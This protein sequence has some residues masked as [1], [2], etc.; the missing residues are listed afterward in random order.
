MAITIGSNSY[1]YLRDAINAAVNNDVILVGAGTYNIL[2]YTSSAPQNANVGYCGSYAPSLSRFFTGKSGINGLTIEGAVDGTT[3]APLATITNITRIYA[4]AKDRGYGLP[5]KWTINNLALQ[6]NVT[7]GSE[8]ILQ[9]GNYG[10]LTNNL[11]DL[12]LKNVIFQG[13]HVGSSGG[14]GVYCDLIAA[15]N[16]TF[17]QV[18]VGSNFGGQQTYVAGTTTTMSSGGSA[19]LFAQGN[20]MLVQDSSFVETGYGNSI[21]FWGSTD[22]TITGNL[23]DGDGQIKQRGQILSNTSAFTTGVDS[24]LFVGGTHLDL[25]DVGGL[26]ITASNNSFDAK[27]INTPSASVTNGIGIVISSTTGNQ[28]LA[29]A[30]SIMIKGNDFKDVNPIV[31]QLS[32]QASGAT[33]RTGTEVQLTFDQNRVYNPVISSFTTFGRFIIGGTSDDVLTGALSTSKNDFISGAQGNDT[34]TGNG[35]DDAFVFA[36]QPGTANNNVDTI[37]DFK[38]PSKGA[39]KI[40]LDDSVFTALSKGALG[41]SFGSKINFD[42]TTKCLFYDPTGSGSI[43]E[44]GSTLK[45]ANFT[46]TSIAPIASDFVVF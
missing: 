16:L 31:V 5:T 25:I 43:T 17:D 14:N 38:A 19:F 27:S 6:F 20:K 45:V 3:G 8:Y 39:D 42:A 4:G 44:T 36:F 35:G 28:T 1:S 26:Q 30:R 29:Q 21:T 22:A 46:G 12:T 32:G 23:F 9:G 37:T 40:W 13:T 11:T 41:S 33:A 18:K 7:S 34:L 15:N 2:D 10:S 24:N